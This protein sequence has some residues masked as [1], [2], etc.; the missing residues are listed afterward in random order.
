[1]KGAWN[2]DLAASVREAALAMLAENGPANLQCAAFMLGAAGTK[3]DMP[4]LAAALDKLVP[5]VEKTG[6]A[7]II[8]EISVPRTA[9]TDL[10]HTVEAL[11][12]RG[13]EPAA[14]PKT[15]AEITHF[16]IA[17]KQ[18]KDFRPAGWEKRCADWAGRDS[19]YLR[20]V[21]LFNTPRPLPEALLPAY[22][23][24]ARKVI[25]TTRELSVIHPATQAARDAQ[26]PAD[27]IL[28]LLADRLDSR[29]LYIHLFACMRE[30]LSGKFE[31]LE[32]D[33]MAT[34]SKPEKV[35]AAKAAWKQFLQENGPAIRGG[36]HFDWQTPEIRRGCSSR[37]AFSDSV[38]RGG[39]P[40][41]PFA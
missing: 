36:K 28:G 25:A 14:D 32:S 40:T 7:P 12:D 24:A 11:V 26:V 16:V 19:P 6:P 23:E 22:Q 39:M 21:L 13:V 20:E 37:R 38:W 1:M 17:L 27:E 35:A 5:V 8:G 2:G 18:R 41:P 3:E 10:L 30:V 9:C 31:M 33:C 34:V 15:P 4:A 29:G